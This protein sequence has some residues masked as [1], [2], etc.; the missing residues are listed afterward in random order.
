MHADV[1]ARLLNAVIYDAGREK[2]VK[3]LGFSQGHGP[4]NLHGGHLVEIIDIDR[5]RDEYSLTGSACRVDDCSAK[6]IIRIRRVLVSE[7]KTELVLGHPISGMQNTERN[8][9][10]FADQQSCIA[11]LDTTDSST[12]EEGPHQAIRSLYT[13]TTSRASVNTRREVCISSQTSLRHA[14][15]VMLECVASSLLIKGNLHR[16]TLSQCLQ[17]AL[18]TFRLRPILSP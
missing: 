13:T 14:G 5:R 4:H 18:H 15:E 12:P 3:E 6:V 8:K 10:C 9:M 1:P 11:I 17:S 2:A 7:P 16:T